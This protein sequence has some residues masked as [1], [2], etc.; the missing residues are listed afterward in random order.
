[1]SVPFDIQTDRWDVVG[2]LTVPS[3][4]CL[5]VVGDRSVGGQE[6]GAGTAQPRTDDAERRGDH[7]LRF[8]ILQGHLPGRGRQDPEGIESQAVYN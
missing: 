8:L 2:P 6:P 4:V 7:G 1:M 5:S 3:A